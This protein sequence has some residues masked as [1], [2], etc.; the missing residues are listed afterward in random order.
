MSHNLNDV[1]NLDDFNQHFSYGL[2][3]GRGT[4]GTVHQVVNRESNDKIVAAI[5][6]VDLAAMNEHLQ[7]N[8][9]QDVKNLFQKNTNEKSSPFV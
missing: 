7:E 6:S 1:K 9:K 8:A 2:R 4:F 3:L 5:K